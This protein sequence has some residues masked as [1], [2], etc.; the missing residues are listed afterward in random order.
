[1]FATLGRV[2]Y[3]RRHVVVVLFIGLVAIGGLFGRDLAAHLSQE[4]WFD[5]TAESAVASRLADDTFGRDTDSDVIALYTAPDGATVDDPQI[6]ERM[7]A[8]FADLLARYPDRIQKIDS[9]WDGALTSGFADESHRYAFA[10]IGLRGEGVA[11]VENFDAIVDDLGVAG[12]TVQLAGLQ[13][14]VGQI[15][16][17]MQSDIHR[18]ELIALPLVAILLFF[19][20]GGV[21]AAL[22]PVLI[23]VMTILGAQGIMRAIAAGIEVNAFA[24]A[25][26]TL[27]SLGLAIDYGLFTVTR[28][29][30]EIAAGR[31]VEEAVVTTVTRAGRTI[32][33]SAAI[34]AVS[35]AALFIY[36]HGVLRSVPY[37]AISAVVL[38]AVL[39]TTMLPAVLAILGRRVDALSWHRFSRTK[40]AEQIDSGVFSR[41]ATAAMRRPVAVAVPLTLVLLALI[42][43]IRGIDF[44]GLSER[45]LAADNPARVAQQDFDGT[46]PQFRTEPL[47]LV[48]IGADNAQL[49]EIR[50]AASATP[51]LTAPFAP[52]TPTRDGINVLEAGLVDD[53]DAGPAIEALRD[54]RAPPGVLIMVAGLPALE[55]DSIQGLIDGLPALLT[56]LVLSSFLLLL[57]AFGSVVLAVKAI[58]VSALSLGATLGVLTW[59][60]V[61]GHASGLFDFTPGPLMFAVL[62]LIVTVVFGLST[63]Y[64]VFLLSRMVEAR[65]NGADTPEAIRYGIAR[66]GGVISAAA[67][68][69][70]VVTGAFAFSDLVLMKYIALGMIFA[71]VLDATVLRMWLVP[72]V[73]KML[74]DLCWWPGFGLSRNWSG[75]PGLD[76][77]LAAG[78]H[79]QRAGDRVRDDLDRVVVDPAE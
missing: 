44:G 45:Y 43:P 14:I 71:L 24:S 63:D 1:M 34:I 75:Q 42:L 13:P 65:A 3:R 35:L 41:I 20:F 38:A 5:E 18:A 46:F 11:T 77:G 23:G 47:R 39:S 31:S 58:V 62:V 26:V 2:V 30:E 78:E 6:A 15:N 40:T 69:L 21:V 25:V 48:V 64:E 16:E 12:M 56:I 59:L 72:A 61:D 52:S 37:G 66:T 50:V 36:P 57:F 55:Y 28:F 49:G 74:G 29:R 76:A 54:L 51:G 70:V 53:D 32:V 9:Y 33:F 8:H 73:M 27:V 60:F 10:S 19:V 4:G 79:E 17:G 68:I 67:A 22:L 7:R